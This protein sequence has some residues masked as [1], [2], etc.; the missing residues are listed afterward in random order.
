MDTEHPQFAEQHVSYHRFVVSG[1]TLV[2]PAVRNGLVSSA[3]HDPGGSP[4]EVEILTG[5]HTGTV[6]VAV[7][8]FDERPEL[9]LLEY[10]AAAE[11]SVSR[12]GER[13]I[14]I[15]DPELGPTDALAP[16]GRSDPCLRLRVC[17]VGRDT[18]YDGGGVHLEERYLLL[19]W[20]DVPGAHSI[21]AT[22][23]VDERL[24]VVWRSPSEG[25]PPPRY[26]KQFPSVRPARPD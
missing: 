17:A 7:V 3:L 16:L 15:S 22:D 18:N 13:A 5:T 1:A 4:P 10:E 19:A 6:A 12:I 23:A 2:G 21:L 25:A 9:R 8:E 24:A 20:P 14:R 11:F 26:A